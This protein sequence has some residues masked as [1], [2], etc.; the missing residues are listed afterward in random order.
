MQLPGASVAYL[1]HLSFNANA[2]TQFPSTVFLIARL[3]SDWGVR[4]SISFQKAS[5]SIKRKSYKLC[6]RSVLHAPFP[7]GQG[8]SSLGQ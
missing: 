7:K 2:C 6:P 8:K 3:L 1:A 4:L 5:V